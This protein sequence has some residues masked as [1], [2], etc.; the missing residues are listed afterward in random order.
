MG[1][2]SGS[3]IGSCAGGDRALVERHPIVFRDAEL[4]LDRLPMVGLGA[5]PHSDPPGDRGLRDAQASR[6]LTLGD[7]PIGLLVQRS[8]QGPRTIGI[9]HP[10]FL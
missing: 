5:R 10:L 6:E 4:A 1:E 3:G 2:R 8:R 9:N 7:R